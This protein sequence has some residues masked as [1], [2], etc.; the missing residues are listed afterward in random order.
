MTGETKHQILNFL[1]AGV[2]LI[3]GLFCK[4]LNLVPRHQEIVAR[5]SGYEDARFLT[6]TIGI[7]ET[8][9][10]VWILS[11]ISS[12][13]NAVVQISLVV[14]MNMLEFIIVP[15]LLL[16]GKFN[17]FFALLFTL[18]IFYNEFYLNWKLFLKQ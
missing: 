17:A 11:K 15:E 10:A 2:W 1:I 16:W 14:I 8:A 6:L 4:V 5:V 9:M 7:L 18:L 12:R 3:N 13:L